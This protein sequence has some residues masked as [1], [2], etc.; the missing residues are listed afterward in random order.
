MSPK[1]SG[2][3][4]AAPC[5]A[6]YA[7][8]AARVDSSTETSATGTSHQAGLSGA[9]TSG[10]VSTWITVVDVGRL[11]LGQGLLELGEIGHRGDPGA[12][13]GGVGRQ[14]DR[15]ATSPSSPVAVR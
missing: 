3:R 6:S 7:V 12:Q 2:G 9:G 15:A 5:S 8:R 13:A 1:D 10:S 14:V 11:R 4:A